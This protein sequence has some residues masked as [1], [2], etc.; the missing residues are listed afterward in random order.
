MQ[1]G[2]AMFDKAF[3]LFRLRH[4]YE[5]KPLAD[6]LQK[7]FGKDT[8]LVPEDLK[9]LLLVVT[10]N[11]STDSP[12]PVS[13]NPYAKYNQTD[14]ADCNLNI[15]LWQL[16]RAS[17]AAPVYFAPEVLQ[18]DP[19]DPSKTFVFE[20]GGLTPYNNPSF[21]LAR[22]AT[23]KQY[24]LNWDSGEDKLLVMSVGTGSAPKTDAQVY[25]SGKTAFTNLANFPS[26]LMYGAQVDQDV[27]CRTM[28]RC[29]HG[30]PID[31]EL[32]D[33]IPRDDD[34]NVIP[35]EQDLGRRFL[36]AR[37]NAELTAK[38]LSDHGLGDVDASQVSQLDSVEHVNDLVR[39]GQK[40]AEEVKIEHFN[41]DRFGQF[42]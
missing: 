19:N 3:I 28:G 24:N 6:E 16:V 38:W 13:S 2:P 8:T 15:P 21:L 10:R 34:G 7:T 36:Y 42:Y 30:A 39:V 27:N 22:M 20:D 31:L 35:L 40:L 25:S 29:V 26:A 37:Y 41:L 5:T 14:S 18:W 17:T 1:A 9:C 33:L 4:L 23:V 11:L 12:W 32:G